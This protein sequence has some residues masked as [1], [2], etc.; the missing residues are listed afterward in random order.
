MTENGPKKI[1]DNVAYL[2]AVGQLTDAIHAP[3]GI[4]AATALT[5]A[6]P[7]YTEI[8]TGSFATP[9]ALQTL[10]VLQELINLP[11]TPR[12]RNF[13]K[14]LPDFIAATL[15]P[16]SFA[17]TP[18]ETQEAAYAMLTTTQQKN[19]EMA[20]SAEKV[21]AA[22]FETFTALDI[23]NAKAARAIINA[24]ITYGGAVQIKKL[25]HLMQTPDAPLLNKLPNL[26]ESIFGTHIL[27][28]NTVRRQDKMIGIMD[29]LTNGHGETIVTTW[30]NDQGDALKTME[31]FGIV[32]SLEKR[33]PG[34]VQFLFEHYGIRSFARYPIDMLIDQ[35]DTREE[36]GVAY[37]LVLAARH[38]SNGVFYQDK[39]EL[40][41]AYNQAKEIGTRL[42]IT[43]VASAAE[44]V[45]AITENAKRHGQLS[46][47]LFMTHGQ[48]KSLM[49]SANE[50]ITAS[51]LLA[52]RDNR[53][54]FTTDASLLF[55]ACL[56]YAFTKDLSELIPD[57]TVH[58][59][60][61]ETYISENGIQIQRVNGVLAV[62]MHFGY[63]EE[64]LPT[65]KDL[66]ID[67]ENFI[68]RTGARR[69]Y[70]VATRVYRNGQLVQDYS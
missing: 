31:N 18:L 38:D 56:G 51:D 70:H 64:N 59:S 53:D 9:Y 13:V 49:I 28:L 68:G 34:I 32:C 11:E 45:Q 2:T 61:Y 44:I 43:E 37:G 69:D 8:L 39:S 58:G 40:L 35:Y 23:V 30:R 41:H 55:T 65:V 26:P 48:E 24:V 17:Q 47:A 57:I 12:N 10:S 19:P 63:T 42:R 46:Y 7:G 22:H 60:D 33:R 20:A 54:C 3:I 52:L 4:D 66:A 21:F 5:N 1:F 6:L 16:V 29:E 15:A 67:D 27:G 50:S 36:T 62:R 25:V 14:A